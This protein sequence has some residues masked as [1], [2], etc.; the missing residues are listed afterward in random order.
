MDSDL[1]SSPD[2]D[3]LESIKWEGNKLFSE[4][5]YKKASE[6]YYKILIDC[7]SLK[8]NEINVEELENAVEKQKNKIQG[9]DIRKFLSKI[10]C[11]LGI[12]H[13]YMEKKQDSVR[14]FK[15]SL[16]F[17][18]QN[19]KSNYHVANYHIT[20]NDYNTALVYI[21][22]CQKIVNSNSK[23]Y[24]NTRQPH[25]D[26][27]DQIKQSLIKTDLSRNN[28]ND[29]IHLVDDI[30]SGNNINLN[31]QRLQLVPCR[32]LFLSESVKSL[33][34]FCKNRLSCDNVDE[35]LCS[36]WSCLYHILYKCD[37]EKVFELREQFLYQFDTDEDSLTSYVVKLMKL[38]SQN[39]HNNSLYASV[40]SNVVKCCPLVKGVDSLGVFVILLEKEFVD[41]E[42][43]IS[44]VLLYFSKQSKLKSEVKHRSS[45]FN[46][47]L[48]KLLE[49]L[50]SLCDD[51]SFDDQH[52]IKSCLMAVF[53]MKFEPYEVSMDTFSNMISMALEP[54]IHNKFSDNGKQSVTFSV[55]WYIV[56]SCLFLSNK[57]LFKSYLVSTRLLEHVVTLYF[58]ESC[59]KIRKLSFELLINCCDTV[60][61]RQEIL[62]HVEDCQTF[63]ELLNSPEF[64]NYTNNVNSETN[65]DL[66]S[67]K[68][69]E[70][71][72]DK[73]KL[74][75]LDWFMQ[76]RVLMFCKLSLHS[77]QVKD[78]VL[79]SFNI[80]RLLSKFVLYN[81][82][83]NLDLE[84][85]LHSTSFASLHEEFKKTDLS[86]LPM[87]FEHLKNSEHL[88]H[89]FLQTVCNLLRGNKDRTCFTEDLELLK[90]DKEQL[91]QLK[92]LQEKLP[93]EAKVTV[94]G[95]YFEGNDESANMARSVVFTISNSLIP[96]YLCT[97]F[98]KITSEASK[99]LIVESLHY[100]ALNVNHR[101]HLQSLGAMRILINVANST[102]YQQNQG[103]QAANFRS[104]NRYKLI[105]QSI[106]HLVIATDP[107]NLSFNDAHDSIQ[108]LMNL[109][110]DENELFQFE[111]CLALTNLLSINDDIRKR[112]FALNGWD[113]F[114]NLLFS[115]NEMLKTAGLEGWCNLCAGD[116]VVHGHFYMKIKTQIEN[117]P[118][119]K[120]YDVNVHD[121]NIML[122]FISPG[123]SLKALSAAS[124]ALALLVRDGRI[125]QYMPFVSRF[126]NVLKTLDSTEDP[127]II[128]RILTVL[129]CVVQSRPKNLSDHNEKHL[130]A[131]IDKIVSSVKRNSHKYNNKTLLDLFH[132][133]C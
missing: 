24:K 93:E 45:K 97:M 32:R 80:F 101:R 105:V 130:N 90:Y 56:L 106:A 84:I 114:T 127:S 46:S 40:L 69:L 18:D 8:T 42:L 65:S 124:G 116:D 66:N 63:I 41:L 74:E 59:Q 55:N 47:L 58:N 104:M 70:A 36:V 11:N 103:S 92:T 9:P 25:L 78:E 109:L 33:V 26:L 37:E 99:A 62:D 131:F 75:G 67:D 4:S 119:D 23:H 86:F 77:Y 38:N 3:R 87:V 2:L 102:K 115:E 21:Q 35:H 30:C 71:V 60:E 57:T 122:L 73:R 12:C 6:V 10:L 129:S 19:Y 28:V 91:N 85:L 81:I 117:T 27:L 112:V 95:N 133:I 43:L 49:N 108:P 128:H 113:K 50:Y 61:F 1:I 15:I 22:N 72:L 44:S 31:I 20:H 118:A 96:K 7:F 88:L 53:T 64:V 29:P 125:A 121:I 5:D 54:Y 107:A 68:K 39:P 132:E 76:T 82:K 100:L 34:N 52:H 13:N 14:F 120:V 51:E 48:L 79:S 98:N 111:S 83:H 89:Y 17:D 126:E 110:D 16:I 123:I 94:N